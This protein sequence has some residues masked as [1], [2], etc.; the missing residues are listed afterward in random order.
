MR[1]ALSS[2]FEGDEHMT[3]FEQVESG[4]K[5]TLSLLAARR[6]TAA[7]LRENA[8]LY[9]ASA[10]AF[11]NYCEFGAL[12]TQ[13]NRSVIKSADIET[14]DAVDTCA[15]H[16]LDN[17]DK[18][19]CLSA[20]D[21][22]RFIN[23]MIGNKLIDMARAHW[24][25]CP[26]PPSGPAASASLPREADDECAEDAR[27]LVTFLDDTA[28]GYIHDKTDVAEEFACREECAEVLGG[29]AASG[30]SAM[31]AFCFLSSVILR[32][33]PAQIAAE[34]VGSSLTDSLKRV[35]AEI[36]LTFRLDDAF[37]ETLL[38]KGRAYAKDYSDAVLE[39]VAAEVSRASYRAKTTLKKELSRRR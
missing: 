18:I 22:L 35:I 15:M 28:W 13:R 11:C 34:L 1:G 24:R 31:D 33:K 25:A 39:D 32:E 10:A 5:E 4:L 7:L 36:A 3:Q 6:M 29:L 12:R 27:S 23:A 14:L 21:Q 30:M 16:C 20:G 38:R 26:K 2:K 19:L 17:L 37:I 8:A 9:N